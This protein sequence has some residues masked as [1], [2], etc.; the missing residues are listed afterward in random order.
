MR[1]ECLSSSSCPTAKGLI[2]ESPDWVMKDDPTH[3]APSPFLTVIRSFLTGQILFSI[4][5]GYIGVC[6]AAAHVGDQIHITL[7]CRQPLPV[8]WSCDF[9]LVGGYDAIA[10]C[11][12]NNE[13]TQID[14]RGGPPPS[15][16]EVRGDTEDIR[17]DFWSGQTGESTLVDLRLSS[18]NLKTLGIELEE[19]MLV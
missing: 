14:P 4:Q 16:W 7:G 1:R 11:D 5:K 2:A 3:H 10:F 15:G 13:R 17:M 9:L 6:S 8:G 19:I 12:P 18:E